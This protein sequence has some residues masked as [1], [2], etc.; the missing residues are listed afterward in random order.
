MLTTVAGVVTLVIVVRSVDADAVVVVQLVYSVEAKVWRL[1]IVTASVVWEIAVVVVVTS[2]HKGA[3]VDSVGAVVYRDGE[4]VSV[5]VT[6]IVV[7]VSNAVTTIVDNNVDN[8]V[9]VT[10]GRVEADSVTVAAAAAL[11]GPPSTGTTEYVTSPWANGPL[12]RGFDVKG[13]AS[14]R[15]VI[16]SNARR[17]VE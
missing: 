7:G 13:S 3:A 10:G 8:C 11:V 17:L 14:V 15:A 1:V 12:L 16:A 5:T 2:E 4:G 9:S 6:T